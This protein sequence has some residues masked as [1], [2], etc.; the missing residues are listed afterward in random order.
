[1]TNRLRIVRD[2][3]RPGCRKEAWGATNYCVLHNPYETPESIWYRE[4]QA[5]VDAICTSLR[6][7][8][9]PPR[10]DPLWHDL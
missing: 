5:E 1:M 4:A 6:E 2:C 7:P 9:K 8:P 3:I 10:F